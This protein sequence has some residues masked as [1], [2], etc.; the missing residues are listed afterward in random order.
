MKYSNNRPLDP[1]M[2]Q[3]YLKVAFRHV[4]VPSQVLTSSG[5]MSIGSP[6]STLLLQR[7]KDFNGKWMPVMFQ[8]GSVWLKIR[9]FW[10]LP[11]IFS[12]NFSSSMLRKNPAKKLFAI[13][14]SPKELVL[15]L[16]FY[17]YSLWYH[18]R[19]HL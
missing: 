15:N 8:Y 17:S 16:S 13:K 2:L 14:Y 5:A 4:L 10:H 7:E 9:F 12:G 1:F 6:H 18:R 11:V 3:K 19:L